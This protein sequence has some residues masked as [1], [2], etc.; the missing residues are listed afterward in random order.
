MD[1]YS[2]GVVDGRV[3]FLKASDNPFG[4]FTNAFTVFRGNEIKS[5]GGVWIS[6]AT[7]DVLVEDTVIENSDHDEVRVDETC[8]A[9][10]VV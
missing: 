9:V 10:L 5:N 6:G 7:R 8:V 4:Q 1:Q 2:L 3:G